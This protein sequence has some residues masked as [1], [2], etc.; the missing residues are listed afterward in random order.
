MKAQWYSCLSNLPK[1]LSLRLVAFTIGTV[2]SWASVATAQTASATVTVDGTSGPWQWVSGGLN[3]AYQYAYGFGNTPGTPPTVIGA[4]NGFPFSVGD[5]LTIGYVSGLSVFVGY[6][7]P[8]YDAN[9]VTNDA[10]NNKLDGYPPA[11]SYYMNPSTYP[12]YLGELVGTFA[13]NSGQ[14]VGTPFGIGDFG[15][16]T[17]PTG[18]TELELGANDDD[19]GD[20]RGSWQIQI[21]EVAVPE[22][23]TTTLV[24]IS[25]IGLGLATR[26]HERSVAR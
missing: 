5:N 9:G 17:I 16:L 23:T 20:N 25:L 7:G 4:G 12:I 24:S 10:L 3:T 15:T 14:I 6:Y 19:Y 1:G 2:A 8:G 22:P 26:R 13:N 11:P 21:T 18:A